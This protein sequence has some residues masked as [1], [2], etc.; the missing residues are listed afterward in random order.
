VPV[1][2]I[3]LFVKIAF[4]APAYRRIKLGQIANLQSTLKC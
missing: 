1:D 2:V 4:H 3:D